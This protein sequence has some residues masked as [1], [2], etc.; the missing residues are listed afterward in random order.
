MLDT[1]AENDG[2]DELDIF[3]LDNLDPN[4][5]GYLPDTVKRNKTDDIFL[6]RALKCIDTEAP[7]AHRHGHA[8]DVLARPTELADRPAFVG[9]L[10]G[11]A[12]TRTAAS[13]ATA[14]AR[15]ATSRSPASSASTTTPRSTAG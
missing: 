4:F 12:S 6:L 8:D 14:T 10:A 13:A 3:G 5:N 15:R 7:F 9:L 11:N 2:V 1:G